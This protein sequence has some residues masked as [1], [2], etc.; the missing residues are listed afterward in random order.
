MN[1]A[2][3]LVFLHKIAEIS[4]YQKE[5]A[6]QLEVYRRMEAALSELGQALTGSAQKLHDR[7]IALEAV[8]THTPTDPPPPT[9]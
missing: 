8:V 2:E 1:D 6:A 9:H 7:I 3:R 5:L 4:A